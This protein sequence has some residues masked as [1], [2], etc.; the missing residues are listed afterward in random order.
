[1]KDFPIPVRPAPDV[2]GPGSQ[3]DE[4]EGFSYMGFPR[5]VTTFSMPLV[6]EDAD[7]ASI[8][9]ARRLLTRFVEQMGNGSTPRVE[10]S[11]I[12][13]SVLRVLNESLGEGEVS[14]RIA[15]RNGDGAE[16]RIQETM[17]AGV[18]R[19]LH[20]RHDGGVEH[21]WL[22]ACPVPPVALERAQ[23]AATTHLAPFEVPRGAM[24][25]PALLTEIREQVLHFRPGQPPHV[26]N[27]TLLPLTTEDQGVLE[28]AA[29]V[30][31][32]AIL[33]R[34]FGNCRITSTA[35]LNLWRVQYFNSMQ[36]LILNTFEVVEVP[37]VAM[38]AAEDLADSRE[39]LQELLDWMGESGSA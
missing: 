27:L 14:V 34:G 3:P 29:P 16:I 23:R 39:R 31:P 15:K 17:F 33:S 18:W 19:E 1:M 12:P 7:A 35:L 22:L 11:S 6:P 4:G 2:I 25:S 8:A 37:E 9:T 26:I 28:Q 24:N 36:T 21:D 38:A 5:E 20:L 30:G 13:A 10:L 32:V